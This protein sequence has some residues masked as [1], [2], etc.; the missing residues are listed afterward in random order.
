M[1]IKGMHEQITKLEAAKYD[2]E[3]RNKVQDYDVSA[4][5]ATRRIVMCGA[6]V[7][8]AERARQAAGTS[9]GDQERSRS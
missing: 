6:T 5:E 3:E 1:R 8:R 7:A 2:L 4:C 9:E